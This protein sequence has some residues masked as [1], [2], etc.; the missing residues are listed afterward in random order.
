MEKLRTDTG[1]K[2]KL[3]LFTLGKTQG[4]LDSGN[5]LAINRHR[6]AL[7]IIVSQIDILKLQTVEERFKEDIVQWSTE[8]ENQVAQVDIRVA[9]INEHLASI[10]SKEDFKAQETELKAKERADQLKFERAQLEQKLEYERKIEESK[11]NYATKTSEAK[12]SPPSEGVRTKLPKPTI[13]KFNGSHTDWLR[14]WN[15]YEAEIDKCSDMPAVT[16]FAYLKDLLESKVRAGIDGLPFSSEGYE[17]AKN[18]LRTKYGKT[19]EIVNAYVQ[20]IMGLPVISGAN[21]ARIHQFYEALSFN[22]QALEMLGKLAVSRCRST[23]YQG[24]E[25]T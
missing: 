3:L 9:H 12:S 18:I 17:R 5:V 20:N 1:G 23:S 22:V 8:I 11:M 6:E 7:S 15:I 10:R 19:S 4:V 21:P 24:L 2:L 16:K 25:T 13:A 14:F